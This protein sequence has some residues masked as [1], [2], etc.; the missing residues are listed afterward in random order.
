[1][2]LITIIIIMIIMII[3]IVVRSS[4]RGSSTKVLLRVAFRV[5]QPGGLNR[6]GLYQNKVKISLRTKKEYIINLTY[7]ME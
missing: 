2:I 3:I 7:A 4:L 5:R 1:M 6:S